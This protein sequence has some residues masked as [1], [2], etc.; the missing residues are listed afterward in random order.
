VVEQARSKEKR[1]VYIDSI[2][3]GTRQVSASY[4]IPTAV[5]K[6]SY[7]L[8]FPA[9]GEP[10]L[11]GW[12]I[13]DNTTGDDWD[14][15]QLAVVSG[16]P[17]SFV[18]NLYEPKYVNRPTAELAEDRA[19][20]PV[21]YEGAMDAVR[22][23]RKAGVAGGVIG[24]IAGGAPAAAP[25]PPPAQFERLQ[26]FGK[27]QAAP[28]LLAQTAQAREAGEL[29]EYRFSTPITIKKSESAMLPFLQ[30]KLGA[31]KL[32]IYSDSYGQH[33]MNAAELTNSTGKTLDGGP[34]TVFDSGSY[35]GEALVETIK[36]GDKRL[37]SYGVDLG[38]RV[39]TAYDSKSA[40]LREIH[41]NRGLLTTR[42]SQQ[43]TTTYTINNVDAKAKTL[44][45]E[46]PARPG[47]TVLDQKPIEKT[48]TA[49]R[50]QVS[51]PANGSQTYAITEE[52]EYESSFAL[53]SL[54]PDVIFD[55]VANK[56]L[57]DAAKRALQ[58]I[59]E[60][61][62]QIA[63]AENEARAA[64]QQISDLN[65]DQNRIRQN[66]MSLNNVTGQ[67]EQVQRYARSLADQEAKIAQLR[68]Q[69]T[70]AN[71]RKQ[72]LQAELNALITKMAF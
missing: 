1:S 16:R 47:Y 67:Q 37:I 68:D 58:Q 63:Q 14:K 28:T 27:L 19:A 49:L 40:N 45:I 42:Y 32:L 38:T 35:A 6:S 5:W 69:S 24:G 43:E 36:T 39:T 3:T 23:E 57:T 4:L 72:A 21:V 59:A 50:F 44:V 10:T 65:A 48:P 15:V 7:R 22:A 29:F 61:K 64:D 9:S 62:E 17:V 46:R 25:T 18:S 31:R 33:P 60:K 66:I 8:L 55:Y 56:K 12:A 34:I 71:R 51:L 54:T 20:A 2:D 52:R 53:T 41:A 13:V 11:E 30:Q 26:Q 70:A